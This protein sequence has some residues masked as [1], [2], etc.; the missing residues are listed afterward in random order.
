[1]H[2]NV[3][4]PAGDRERLEHL[5]RYVLRPPVAQDSLELAADGR[6]LLE[7]RR[8]WRDG[9]R[10]ILFE[11]LDFLARLAALVPKPRVN[12]VPRGLR[13]PCKPPPPRDRHCQKPARWSTGR[14]YHRGR[15]RSPE[16]PRRRRR[17]AGTIP[18]TGVHAGRAGS[19]R[20]PASATGDHVARR[21]AVPPDP[22]R[23]PMG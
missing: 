3:A 7:I 19:R 22:T 2:A 14:R 4:V 21:S 18:R 16:R 10:A 13:R 6:V 5:C 11:P 8:P 9:T 15:P 20:L 17:R 12:L 1:V 23:L